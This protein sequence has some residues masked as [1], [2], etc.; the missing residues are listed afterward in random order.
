VFI[1]EMAESQGIFHLTSASD[2]FCCLH[3][4]LSR[5]Q[6]ADSKRIEDAFFLVMGANHLREWIALGYNPKFKK[7]VPSPAPNSEAEK[8]YIEIFD[9]DDF[10]IVQGLCNRAK[11]LTANCVLTGYLGDLS[12]DEW[13]LPIDDVVDFDEGP[14]TGFY[15][16]G[17]EIGSILHRL[18]EVYRDEWFEH[19]RSSESAV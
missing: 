1:E 14:P 18:L 3:V 10:K 4:A 12:I 13:D 8:F 17:Q 7:G 11:H 2:L 5:Y 19:Q 15:V 6:K 16:D 9:N